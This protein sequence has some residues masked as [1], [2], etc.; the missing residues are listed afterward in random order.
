MTLLTFVLS[1]LSGASVHLREVHYFAHIH[2]CTRV[3]V[4]TH[5]SFHVL[6][7]LTL[8]SSLLGTTLSNSSEGLKKIRHTLALLAYTRPETCELVKYLEHAK[9]RLPEN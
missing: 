4:H 2:T 8:T 1:L 5:T 6:W 3:Y 9:C 7:G